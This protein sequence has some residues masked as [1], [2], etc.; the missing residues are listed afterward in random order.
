MLYLY[1]GNGD[2]NGRAF[3]DGDTGAVIAKL[4]GYQYVSFDI[5]DTLLRRDVPKP[6]DVF[7]LM[8]QGIPRHN[9]FA[10]SDFAAKRM[11]AERLA[12]SK[13]DTEI[14]LDDIYDSFQDE[15]VLANKERLKQME[16]DIELAVSCPDERAKRIYKWCIE[17]QK[18]VYLI[19][20]MY[21]PEPFIGKLLEKGGISPYARL[22]VSN[23]CKY[24][25]AQNG[26]L[27]A[28][29]CQKE[30]IRPEQLIH[31]GDSRRSDE[32]GAK[33]AGCGAILF[34]PA[35]RTE[36]FSKRSELPAAEEK[37]RD[38]LKAFC[39]NRPE[40]LTDP[41]FSFGYEGLGPLLLGFSQWLHA[42]LVQKGIQRAFFFSRDGLIMKKAFD[43]L[44]PDSAIKTEYL[45]VSR[46]SLRVPQLWMD[47]RYET[48]LDSL[49]AAS[50][51]SIGQFLDS[52]GS[53]WAEHKDVCLSL[54]INEDY[55][56]ALK[57]ARQNDKLRA[58]YHA[59]ESELY[60]NSVKEYKA[61]AAYLEEMNFKGKTAVVDIGWRG[62]MQSFLF[63]LAGKL[64]SDVSM[65]GY[66]MG[67]AAG[68]ETYRQ[69]MSL[70][71]SGYLFD[72]AANQ[73]DKDLRSPFVGVMESL[74]LSQTGSVMNYTLDEEGHCRVNLYPNEYEAAPGQLTEDA[75]KIKT[76]QE[77]ALMFVRDAADSVLM[78][79]EFSARVVFNNIYRVGMDPSQ[80]EI[81]MFG[82]MEFSD[83]QTL[84]LAKPGPLGFYLLHPKTL[85]TDFY[86]SRWK[87]G[88]MKR[89]L[90]LPLPYGKLYDMLKKIQG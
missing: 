8:E 72:C 39:R 55:V 83:G 26:A 40:H 86:N 46:R 52:V 36:W 16:M 6:G 29:V 22:Y 54:G 48:V 81:R 63:R 44:Y 80:S 17:N 12:R 15:T 37:Q 65:E 85:I 59:I 3:P 38:V 31:I 51:Q 35:R 61:L 18:T 45:L 78:H 30:G 73:A 25:K 50:V 88:F 43:T 89:L 82:D 21:L 47:M 74:F 19:S 1:G 13:S 10:V 33:Q 2:L 57:N 62:S 53:S 7:E 4:A 84:Y 34:R 49:P 70:N 23:A 56:F 41:F 75:Q 60:Q 69:K 58:L 67:L 42:Q 79:C 64:G 28:F 76:L 14:T 71:F 24:R 68:A 9:G 66:Y 5:F 87:I 77:G 27:F 32:T 11:A 20:D 90:K